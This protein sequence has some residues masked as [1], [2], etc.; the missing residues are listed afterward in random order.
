V[1]KHDAARL[2]VQTMAD[3]LRGFLKKTWPIWVLVVLG[4]IATVTMGR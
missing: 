2:A 3:D 1:G 4:T